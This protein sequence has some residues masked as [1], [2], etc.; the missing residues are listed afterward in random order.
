MQKHDAI[1]RG[2]DSANAVIQTVIKRGI[3]GENLDA[4]FMSITKCMLM[5]IRERANLS[6][7][8]KSLKNAIKEMIESEDWGFV[9][10]ALKG[11]RNNGDWDCKDFPT[12]VLEQMLKDESFPDVAKDSV[13][14]ELYKRK[15]LNAQS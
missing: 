10:I 5:I 15:E 7:D 13:R 3:D 1:A 11:N 8:E 12:V 4:Y 14:R 9:R 6:I 2:C